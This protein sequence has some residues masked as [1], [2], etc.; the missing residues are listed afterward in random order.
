MADHE[1]AWPR[2]AECRAALEALRQVTIQYAEVLSVVC[3]APALIDATHDLIAAAERP[4]ASA[5]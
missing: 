5:S 3:E 4:D 2:A 1:R